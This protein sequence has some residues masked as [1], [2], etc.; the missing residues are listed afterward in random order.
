M[1][2]PKTCSSLAWSKPATKSLSIQQSST[3][4]LARGTSSCSPSIPSIVVRRAVLTP[5]SSTPS[6]TSTASTPAAKKRKRTPP[7]RLYPTVKAPLAGHSERS[8][9][10]W[11]GLSV[12]ESDESIALTGDALFHVLLA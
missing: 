5:W 10:S 6:S 12:T 9:E 11:L 2:T 7:S 8:E 4:H 1:P 3:R